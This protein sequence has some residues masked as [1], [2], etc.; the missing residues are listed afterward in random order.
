[1]LRPRPGISC[2]RSIFSP[3]SPAERGREFSFGYLKM[4]GHL[5]VT[6]RKETMEYV[7]LDDSPMRWE[8]CPA[9]ARGGLA[10]ARGRAGS[11]APETGARG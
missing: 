3:S 2:S 4:P 6:D 8:D 1:M 7:I 10:P 9:L 11:A 5:V